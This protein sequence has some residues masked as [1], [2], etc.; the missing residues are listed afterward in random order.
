V[1][2]LSNIR[3]LEGVKFAWKFH[4]I[5][6]SLLTVV[7]QELGASICLPVFLCFPL[8]AQSTPLTCQHDPVLMQY[9]RHPE[10]SAA[11]Q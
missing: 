3:I 6:A 5:L 8:L 2:N 10:R 11:G 4:P 1:P 7:L 9:L